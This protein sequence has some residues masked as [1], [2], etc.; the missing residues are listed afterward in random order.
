[1]GIFYQNIILHITLS[2][3]IIVINSLYFDAFFVNS[4]LTLPGQI[5]SPLFSTRTISTSSAVSVLR[6]DSKCKHFLYPRM[7]LACKGLSSQNS[8]EFFLTK[9]CHNPVLL[10]LRRNSGDKDNLGL[11]TLHNI[12]P[13]CPIMAFD[14]DLTARQ[15]YSVAIS[16]LY[17]IV[18]IFTYFDT[19][20]ALSWKCEG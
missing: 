11:E 10:G 6:N 8:V 7:H 5:S 14:V 4:H 19:R 16:P 17:W 1:M 18:L 2:N 3:L 13:R 15:Q 9:V 20:K 12:D